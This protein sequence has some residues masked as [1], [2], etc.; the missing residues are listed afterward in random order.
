MQHV[1]SSRKTRRCSCCIAGLRDCYNIS[2]MRSL[3][4]LHV[5]DIYSRG[6]PPVKQRIRNEKDTGEG[7]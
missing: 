5:A 2:G 7:T 3:Y 6:N 1:A 4:F